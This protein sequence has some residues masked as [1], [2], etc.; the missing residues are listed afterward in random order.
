MK[1]ALT[2][3]P[4]FDGELHVKVE[5]TPNGPLVTRTVTVVLSV[6]PNEVMSATLRK[7]GRD[8]VN[9]PL[10]TRPDGE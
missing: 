4:D 3:P 9:Q 8:L 1:F 7:L 2:Y 6:S 5:D 10:R